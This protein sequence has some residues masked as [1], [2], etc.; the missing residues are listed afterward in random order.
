MSSLGQSQASGWKGAPLADVRIC[1]IFEHSLSHYTRILQEVVALRASGATVVLLTSNAYTPDEPRDILRT[2][3]P[4]NLAMGIPESRL[5][6]RTARVAHN[7]GLEVIRKVSEML[8]LRLQSRARIRT[9]RDLAGE[10]DIFWVIDFPSLPTALLVARERDV[11]VLYETVDLVPEYLYR[12][13]RYR[14]RQ[15][16]AERAAIRGVDGFI[17]AAESY[18][19]YYMERYS[20][21]GLVRRPVVRDNMPARIVPAIKPTQRPLRMLFLGSLM[22]DRP[23]IELIEAMALARSD[24]TLTLQGKNLLG[25]AVYA[26]I[27]ELRLD[28]RVTIAGP[29]APHQIVDSAAEYDVGV[30]ALRG[31][32]EN[33]RRASTS[34]LFAYIAAGLAILGSDLPGIRRIVSEHENG[35][36]VDGTNPSCWATAIDEIA[37]LPLEVIDS[38]KS[39]SL[40]AAEAYSWT[41]QQPAYIQE[42]RRALS[43]NRED[44]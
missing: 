4:L 29:T 26:R 33:E 2:E 35:I 41:R 25:D 24:A 34:K 44:T 6:W 1:L 23:V 7:L 14:Q 20:G 10:I 28:G 27:R 13:Q 30:V 22:F 12:G 32:D 39:R 40:A 36:L 38:M 3:A 18:A 21:D 8:P 31:D 37:A 19:D 5:S 42:F 9:L 11:R 15:L 17:T 43:H 16:E